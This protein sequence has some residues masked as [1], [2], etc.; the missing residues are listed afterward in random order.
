MIRLVYVD[1]YDYDEIKIK[2]F[3]DYDEFGYWYIGYGNWE[4]IK[5][6][7]IVKE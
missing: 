1:K 2:N 3:K 7:K 4:D 6:I 5:I